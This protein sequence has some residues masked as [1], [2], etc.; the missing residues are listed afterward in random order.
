MATTESKS[1]YQDKSVREQFKFEPE[2]DKFL[3]I[4]YRT[5]CL[6]CSCGFDD[7]ENCIGAQVN[8]R[9]LC[10]QNTADVSCFQCQDES[11]QACQS[12]ILA[13]T[14]CDNT[15]EEFDICFQ[16]QRGVSC[17][18]IKGGSSASCDM[19]FLE[20]TFICCQQLERVLCI[21]YRSAIPC[22][23]DVP[24]EC[25]ICGVILMGTESA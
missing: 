10:I 16:G 21:H 5:S 17:C 2:F 1:V 22:T 13:M 25:A 14:A 4:Q 6:C 23:E 19:D 20:P 24:M 8:A 12:L 9:V 7:C 15:G 3:D 11:S 18:C